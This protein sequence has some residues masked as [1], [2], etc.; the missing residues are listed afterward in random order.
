[1]R[2]ASV[3]RS[4]FTGEAERS[5]FLNRLVAGTRDVLRGNRGLAEHG[6]YHEFCR[7]LGRL[8]TNYQLSELVGTP[9]SSNGTLRKRAPG[10]TLQEVSRLALPRACGGAHERALGCPRPWYLYILR[11]LMVGVGLTLPLPY[12][13]QV[14][15]DSYHEWI[16]LVA[17]FTVHS[18]ESW[19]WAAASVYYLLGLWSRLVSSLPYLK[20]EAP[21]LLE[22]YVPKITQAYLTSRRGPLAPPAI[23]LT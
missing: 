6:N 5:A 14:S 10:Q 23:T 20:G 19:Q 16:R 2:L 11:R 3:R 7:L 17:A 15:V 13:R 8:K 4:L 18:L 21:S 12:G 1:V 22:T 9:P